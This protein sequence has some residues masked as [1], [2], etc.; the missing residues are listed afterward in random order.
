MEPG[1]WGVQ[2][3]MYVYMYL[4]NLSG[5]GK[6]ETRGN[7]SLVSYFFSFSKG[8]ILFYSFFLS[9]FRKEVRE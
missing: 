7:C 1:G 9:F 5:H 4:C 2:G 8:S 3:A 6:R